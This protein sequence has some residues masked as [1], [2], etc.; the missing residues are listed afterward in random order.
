MTVAYGDD[1]TMLVDNTGTNWEDDN[2]DADAVRYWLDP[3]IVAVF[4]G[5]RRHTGALRGTV[6][7]VTWSIPMAPG[8][9]FE[10]TD[11]RQTGSGHVQL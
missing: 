5:F 1:G 4:P 2:D 8:T 7:S 6:I 10:V 9:A 3:L 11:P